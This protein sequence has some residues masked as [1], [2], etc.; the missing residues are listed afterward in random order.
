[1]VKAKLK[2]QDIKGLLLLLII[3]AAFLAYAKPVRMAITNPGMEGFKVSII[4]VEYRGETAWV[5]DTSTW[6]HEGWELSP[7]SQESYI[8]L[9]IYRYT[10]GVEDKDE[11]RSEPCDPIVTVSMAEIQSKATQK[12]TAESLRF[13]DLPPIEIVDD[14]GDQRTVKKL[15]PVVADVW[16]MIKTDPSGGTDG[17]RN[18]VVWMVI[19]P[20]TWQRLVRDPSTPEGYRLE[21][22]KGF[23]IPIAVYVKEMYN[24][25]WITK[26][27]EMREGAPD[28]EAEDNVRIYPN[29][30]GAWLTLYSAPDSNFVWRWEVDPERF[31][32]SLPEEVKEWLASYSPDW[33][34]IQEH[35][36]FKITIEYLEPHHI[37]WGPFEK[38][39]YPSIVF[40][41]RIVGLAYGEWKFVLTK[42][43][44]KKL[45]YK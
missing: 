21:E 23:L 45:E 41:L 25:L 40:K 32:E 33:Q 22:K 31:V 38:V 15:Y 14:K 10:Q 11:L 29:T 12:F 36:F 8:K 19:D 16:V 20:I 28:P 7:G 4:K 44:A 1:M 24:W 42:G 6:K 3:I 9:N 35:W 39:Y 37:G 18:I 5:N 27:G 43:V 13:E 30:E 34:L 2:K 17:V 26:D